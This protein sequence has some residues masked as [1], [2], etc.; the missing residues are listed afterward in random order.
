VAAWSKNSW[1]KLKLSEYWR[2]LYT[3]SSLI[4]IVYVRKNCESGSIKNLV[5]L[6]FL[7]LKH[8]VP[9]HRGIKGNVEADKL[10][11]RAHKKSS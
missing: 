1:R 3:L 8:Y 6:L 5:E 7:F 2:E 9:G 4:K 10:A 11:R